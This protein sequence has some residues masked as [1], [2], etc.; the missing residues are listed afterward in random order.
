MEIIASKQSGLFPHPDEINLQ[1]SCLDY[2]TL[3]KHV[4][5][6]LYGVGVRLDEKPEELFIL[7]HMDHYELLQAAENIVK[8]T[9]KAKPGRKT[10]D[11]TELSSIFAI[12]MDE[13]TKL[14]PKPKSKPTPKK[15][16]NKK[17]KTRLKTKTKK[18]A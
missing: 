12:E 11:D 16:S 18:M 4:A 8:L 5:A 3:C 15:K 7:R 6:V 14:V 10:F 9:P 1:C 17:S 13:S 2:A